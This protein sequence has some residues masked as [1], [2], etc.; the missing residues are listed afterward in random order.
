MNRFVK[1]FVV[2]FAMLG[3]LAVAGAQGDSPAEERVGDPFPLANCPVSGEPLGTMGDPILVMHE[4]RE[5]RLCCKGCVEDF[6]ANAEEY[7][8][9]IDAAIIAQQMHF[10]PTTECVVSGESLEGEDASPIDYVYGNR[11][12]RFCCKMCRREFNDDPATY[13]AKLDAMIIEQ[14]A[15]DYPLTECVISGDPLGE[16]EDSINMVYANHLVRFCCEGCIG[17]FETSPAAYLAKLDAAWGLEATQL[18]AGEHHDHAE[19]DG[20]QH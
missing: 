13:L 2:P 10:Y 9:E 6:N 11:L 7:L 5:I 20:H 1:A 19:G 17:E 4:G 18:P 15:A 12:V 3:A 16:M 14:Q 8:K